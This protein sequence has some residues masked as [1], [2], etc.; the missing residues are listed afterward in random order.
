METKDFGIIK[1]LEESI[2]MNEGL[3]KSIDDASVKQNFDQAIDSICGHYDN[4]M[5]KSHSA[6]YLKDVRDTIAE[7]VEKAVNIGKKL[8]K[9]EQEVNDIINKKV[10]L[11]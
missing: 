1:S 4:A 9:T 3:D 11:E 5:K 10:R 8:G 2:N 6:K 7:L